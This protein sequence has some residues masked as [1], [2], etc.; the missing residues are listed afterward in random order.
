MSALTEISLTSTSMKAAFPAAPDP[1]QRILM[2]VSLIDLMLHICR[3][4]Q[5]Q[6]TPASATLNMLFCAAS[7]C[8][9]S[10]FMN[11]AYPTNFFPVPSRS[12]FNPGLLC[13]Q[14]RQ[15]ARDTQ[16]YQ[17]PRP[18]NKSRHHH[19][20]RRSL[21]CFPHEST[22]SNSRD[23][24]ANLHETW[25]ITKY[26][27]TM[28][29]D[30]GE[31]WQQMAADWHPTDRFEPLVTRLFI[32]ASYASAAVPYPSKVRYTPTTMGAQTPRYQPILLGYHQV[33]LPHRPDVDGGV[34][35]ARLRA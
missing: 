25:F 15:R 12:R 31:N 26:A 4:L 3:C 13:M 28:T 29:K 21:R 20:E 9:Y 32:G 6:K 14:L 30:R 22:H 8:L 2:L 16:S 33:A 10:F 23:V 19:H 17:C 18:K 5:T 7:P 11:E 27:K 24:R 34:E 35:A 1:I